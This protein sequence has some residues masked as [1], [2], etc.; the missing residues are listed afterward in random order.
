[1]KEE[2]LTTVICVHHITV[3]PIPRKI[4]STRPIS[5]FL[6]TLQLPEK[7]VE[8]LVFNVPCTFGNS[9]SASVLV[10][11]LNFLDTTKNLILLV[12]DSEKMP[13]L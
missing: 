3:H 2:S 12:L 11:R 4:I 1:M 9:T 10:K 13:V 5:P 6:K 8:P 7:D